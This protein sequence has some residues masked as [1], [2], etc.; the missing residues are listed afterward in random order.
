MFLLGPLSSLYY[1]RLL[2]GA[3]GETS[4]IFPDANSSKLSKGWCLDS[5]AWSTTSWLSPCIASIYLEDSA[6]FKLSLRYLSTLLLNL[7]FLCTDFFWILVEVLVNSFL[8]VVF[9]TS[10][11]SV[12][13]MDLEVADFGDFK[14]DTVWTWRSYFLGSGLLSPLC[15]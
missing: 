9:E 5:G 12:F 4:F 2:S 7:A 8:S 6:Y 1:W 10:D 14:C 3:S 15:S 13:N 11:L